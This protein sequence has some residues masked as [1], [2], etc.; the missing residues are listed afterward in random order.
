MKPCH[1]SSVALIQ[2]ANPEADRHILP[3]HPYNGGATYKTVFCSSQ[4]L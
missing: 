2:A 3:Y 4:I 1:G